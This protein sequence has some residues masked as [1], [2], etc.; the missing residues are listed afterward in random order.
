MTIQLS[1]NEISDIEDV[2]WAVDDCADIRTDYSGR[3][4][5]GESCFGITFD[6][7]GNVF[8]FALRLGKEHPELAEKFAKAGL[9]RQD[10]MG[11]GTIFYWERLS[12]EE[13]DEE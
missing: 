5:Y 3:G 8:G 6:G 1:T 2:L 11:L 13:D 12:C 10:S 9:P 7:G 4:M